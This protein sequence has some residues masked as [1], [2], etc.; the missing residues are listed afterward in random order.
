[1][2]G[3][4]FTGIQDSLW[5]RY[6]VLPLFRV[7]QYPDNKPL[8]NLM[9]TYYT[10]QCFAPFSHHAISANLSQVHTVHWLSDQLCFH[11][12]LAFTKL[13]HGSYASDLIHKDQNIN[14]YCMIAWD[15]W[16]S[17]I[18][19]QEQLSLHTAN[20]T[21]AT[22]YPQSFLYLL[23]LLVCVYILLIVHGWIK[24]AAWRQK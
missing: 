13:H 22:H 7:F 2:W 17:S 21:T 16:S 4:I 1:M 6:S 11:L 3:T 8:S 15:F 24:S 14:R 19:G 18:G 10:T 23:Q 5:H 12:N 9:K 20:H